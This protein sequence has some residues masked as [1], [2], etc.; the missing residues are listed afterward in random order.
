MGEARLRWIVN[1]RTRIAN[2]TYTGILWR[3]SIFWLV[4]RFNFTKSLAQHT[5]F[6]YHKIG[7]AAPILRGCQPQE[8]QATWGADFTTPV[9]ANASEKNVNI[10]TISYIREAVSMRQYVCRLRHNLGNT[11]NEERLLFDHRH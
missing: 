1:T 3:N 4:K 5:I 9:G 2:K 10:H 8:A 11:E 6:W 7:A